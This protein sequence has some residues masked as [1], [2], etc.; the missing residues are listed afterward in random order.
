MDFLKIMEDLMMKQTVIKYF[1]VVLLTIMSVLGFSSCEVYTSPPPPGGSNSGYATIDPDLVGTWELA[2]VNGYRINGYEVN[3]LDFYNNGRGYYYYYDYG[4]EYELGFDFW[5]EYTGNSSYLFINYHDGTRAEMAYWF[6]PDY[7]T[8]YLQW[9]EGGHKVTYTYYY[10]SDMYWS[11]Q[12]D[13]TS[14]T[15]ALRP[16]ATT[17][18]RLNAVS[19]AKDSVGN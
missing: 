19:P 10:V 17:L 4:M 6:S 2:Y 16:G 8:L 11:P 3:Y 18:N 5:S 12:K 13:T 1:G 15:F 9:W 7:Y 14:S